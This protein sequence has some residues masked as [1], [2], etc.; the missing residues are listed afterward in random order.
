MSTTL[1]IIYLFYRYRILTQCRKSTF[2]ESNTIYDTRTLPSTANNAD[3][4]SF[5]NAYS[6]LN[7]NDLQSSYE[8]R[9]LERTQNIRLSTISSVMGHNTIVSEND[10]NYENTNQRSTEYANLCFKKQ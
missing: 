6:S 10:G 2:S 9:R 3:N 4:A 5:S 7:I 1:I 8:Y